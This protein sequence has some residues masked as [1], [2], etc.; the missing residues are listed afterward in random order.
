MRK[1]SKG[2]EFLWKQVDRKNEKSFI[3]LLNENTKFDKKQFKKLIK[4]SLKINID[5][6]NL[7]AK[8]LDI[9]Y[10]TTFLFYCHAKKNDIYKIKNYKKVKDKFNEKYFHQIRE[11]IQKFTKIK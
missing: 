8:I 10:F 4:F 2:L 5:N 6:A 3:N 9:L 7:K 1:Q 11:I